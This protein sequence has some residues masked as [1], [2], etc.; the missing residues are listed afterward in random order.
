MVIDNY[1]EVKKQLTELAAIINSF[2]S[3]AVQL[4]LI[5]LLYA[6]P[7]EV[8]SQLVSTMP[9]QETAR[10]RR[11]RTKTSKDSGQTQTQATSRKTRVNS[12][13][14]TVGPIIDRLISE[15]YFKEPKMIGQLID[16]CDKKLAH[17]FK[18]NE[19]SPYLTLAVRAG[20]LQR[21]T[22]SENHQYEYY[23]P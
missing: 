6:N 4:R 2:K 21:R 14:L 11:R 23:Q 17:K 20:K 22:N 8:P 15:G 5:E 13:K 19:L 1:E 7:S 18:S 3:E 16:Y 9:I 12:S 10:K